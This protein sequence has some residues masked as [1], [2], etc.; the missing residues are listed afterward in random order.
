MEGI[1]QTMEGI[2]QTAEGNQ[3]DECIHRQDLMVVEEFQTQSFTYGYPRRRR[4]HQTRWRRT[5][6]PSPPSW[7]TLLPLS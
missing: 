5:N 7:A 1:G 2:G 6:V 3:T 4:W